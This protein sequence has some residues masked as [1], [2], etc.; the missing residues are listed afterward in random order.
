MKSLKSGLFILLT[1]FLF[2]CSSGSGS[3]AADQQ[4][5]LQD[6]AHE[7]AQGQTPLNDDYEIPDAVT[8]IAH[9]S[10]D[11]LSEYASRFTLGQTTSINQLSF[12][13]I[14]KGELSEDLLIATFIVTVFEP[15]DIDE[16]IPE[17]STA[18]Q[19]ILQAQAKKVSDIDDTQSVYSFNIEQSNLFNLTS[20]D[21]FI[22]IMDSG[23]EGFEFQWARE[24][25]TH[26]STGLN[27]GAS[28]ASP[29]SLWQAEQWGRNLRL[30]GSCQTTCIIEGKTKGS[31]AIVNSDY[32]AQAQILNADATDP[33]YFL[34]LYESNVMAADNINGEVTV[35]IKAQE[36]ENVTIVLSAYNATTWKISVEGLVSVKNV[37]VLGYQQGTV[38]GLID[39]VAIHSYSFD[40]GNYLGTLSEW[41]DATL[42][43]LAQQDKQAALEFIQ[44]VAGDVTSYSVVY[45]ADGF[46]VY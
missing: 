44:A 10:S 34:G 30:A 28:K 1:P 36:S 25:S 15:N 41:P 6:L 46:V 21:Y 42:E 45:S 27:G 12:S 24:N 40:E 38:T 3:S 29:Q 11:G 35:T 14:V 33:I 32:Q 20:G 31:I 16:K 43:D 23:T 17:S 19:L 4:T 39:S 8:I 22:S 18:T 13:A 37:Y 7:L 26:L 2:A 5:D 9:T